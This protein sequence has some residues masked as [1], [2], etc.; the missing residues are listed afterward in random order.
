MDDDED[1][2]SNYNEDQDKKEPELPPTDDGLSLPFDD[3]E[4]EI[5]LDTPKPTNLLRSLSLGADTNHNS[6][7]ATVSTR[8]SQR[9]A[10]ISSTK[11]K[12]APSIKTIKC[13]TFPDGDKINITLFPKTSRNVNKV[14]LIYPNCQSVEYHTADECRSELYD[15]RDEIN[16]NIMKNRS[17]MKNNLMNSVKDNDATRLWTKATKSITSKTERNRRVKHL[18][19]LARMNL[20]NDPVLIYELINKLADNQTVG[21]L[22]CNNNKIIKKCQEE[23]ITRKISSLKC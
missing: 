12:T 23:N 9:I 22:L 6:S 1:N 5:G 20:D 7:I 13:K 3:S 2:D 8:K 18:E 4:K 17:W 19:T 10:A 15:V 14:S 16:D 11:S 21:N